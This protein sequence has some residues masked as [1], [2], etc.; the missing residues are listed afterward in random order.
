MVSG[1][2]FKAQA[3][4]A[5]NKGSEAEVTTGKS[6]EPGSNR[7]SRKKGFF[8]VYPAEFPGKPAVLLQVVFLVVVFR[9]VECLKLL[10]TGADF[11]TCFLHLLP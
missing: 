5:F 11:F 9:Q 1:G 3:F 2:F 10:H 4:K 7:R 8:R 6:V